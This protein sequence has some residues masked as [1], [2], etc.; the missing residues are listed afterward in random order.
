MS[1][2]AIES[3]SGAITDIGPLYPFVGT[4]M[5]LV[6]VAVLAWLLWHVVELRLEQHEYDHSDDEAD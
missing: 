3:F 5:L 6:G 4:E 2:G 1:T